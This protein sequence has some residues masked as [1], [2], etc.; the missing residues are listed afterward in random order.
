VEGPVWHESPQV[1]VRGRMNKD[2]NRVAVAAVLLVLVG[3]LLLSL[4]DLG[5]GSS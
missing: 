2:F 4:L 1:Q 5:L 3:I